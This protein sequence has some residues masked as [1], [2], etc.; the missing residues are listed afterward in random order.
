MPIS[1]LHVAIQLSQHQ[2][3]IFFTYCISWHRC[4]IPIN[5]DSFTVQAGKSE[6]IRGGHIHAIS[7][8]NHKHAQIEGGN[9]QGCLQGITALT[10]FQ[11]LNGTFFFLFFLFFW[12]GLLLLL[13]FLL[14]LFLPLLLLLLLF[15]FRFIYFIYVRTLLLSEDTPESDPISEVVSH[16]VVAGN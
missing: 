9:A 14:S 4:Q 12:G 8:E 15:F 7:L 6:T 1:F 16:H 3:N 11:S 10:L 2:K 5:H 13:L